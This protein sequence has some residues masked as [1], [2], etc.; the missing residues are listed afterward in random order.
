M[1]D[2]FKKKTKFSAIK[3]LL[4]DHLKQLEDKKTLIPDDIFD[5]TKFSMEE[6]LSTFESID[7][8]IIKND[9]EGCAKLSRCILET[10]INL[11]YIYKEDTE[12][13]A[14]NFKLTSVK[15]LTDKF[16][17]LEETTLEAEKMNDYFT[18]LLKD[19]EPEKNIRDKFKAVD[20][21]SIY[22][23][24]YKRLSEYIHPVYRPQKI[25]FNENR[26]YINEIK[27]TI[28]SDTSLV[29][30]TSLVDVCTKFDLDGGIMMIYDPEYKGFIYFATNPK[31]AQENMRSI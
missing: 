23:R 26:P 9:F 15:K 17:S 31:K 12:N 14:K 27:R 28:R 24:S 29:T 18:G 1:F 30:L 19:Y 11:Q 8:L 6:L 22:V 7:T 3:D 10:S 5:V 13:R 16:N 20:S 25:D 21:D 2:L 4:K